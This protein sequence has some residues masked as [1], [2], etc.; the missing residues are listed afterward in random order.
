[1]IGRVVGGLHLGGRTRPK[2]RPRL[3]LRDYL[4]DSE[5]LPCGPTQVDYS[6]PA[7]DALTLIYL[8]DRL[9]DCVIAGSA[10]LRGVTSSNAGA[11]CVTFQDADIVTLY[12]AIGGYVDGDPSTDNGCDEG[13]ALA[14][15][16]ATGY[17]DGVKLAGSAGVD[18][19]NQEEV[20]SALWLF[21]N[22]VFGIELPDEW[23][24]SM[25][26]A[27]GFVWDL[28]GDPNPENGHCVVGVGYTTQGVIISTWGMLGL[29][30]WGAVAK[31]AAPAAGGELHVALSPDAINRAT[32]KAPTGFDFGTLESDLA[33]VAA[34]P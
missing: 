22:L 3:M 23:V 16:A 6:P 2:H 27:S 32:S 5:T 4:K 20:E 13:T 8:N 14:Y 11:A 24:A 15:L 28:A 10:H 18:A 9:G 34:G 7:A 33:L 26:S 12:G 29:I 25:P 1:M 30:T 21:E 17:P 31:Y 19:T